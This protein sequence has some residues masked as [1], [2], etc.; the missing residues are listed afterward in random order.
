VSKVWA[1]RFAR[2]SIFEKTRSE[3]EEIKRRR[4]KE[5]EEDIYIRH[6]KHRRIIPHIQP[7]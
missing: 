7:W 2:T 5:R 6:F 4:K 1:K 3:Q